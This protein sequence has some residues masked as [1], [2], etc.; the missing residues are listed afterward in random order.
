MAQ[1]SE[2]LFPGGV[3][4]DGRAASPFPLSYTRA[5]KAEKVDLD[6]NVVIDYW[7]GNGALMLGHNPPAVT[8]AIAAQI[9]NGTHFGGGHPYEIQ[10]AK[11]IVELVPSAEQVRFVASGTAATLLALR[12]ARAKTGRTRIARFEGHF[13]GWNDWM[14]VGNRY[15]FDRPS[16]GGIPPSVQSEIIVLPNDDFSAAE[17]ALADRDVAGIILEPG[18]GTQGRVPLANTMLSG[19]RE[20]CDA[21]D[22]TLIF[23]EVVSGFRVD[24]GGVQRQ[25]GITPDITTLAKIAAGGLPGGAVCGATEYMEVLSFSQPAGRQ[26]IAHPGTFNANPLTAV[27]GTAMLRE[28]EDGEPLDRAAGSARILRDGLN[29]LIRVAGIAGCAYGD[30]S[31][32]HVLLGEAGERLKI[33]GGDPTELS[34]RGALAI[35]PDLLSGWRT[36]CMYHGLDLMGPTMMVSSVHTGEVVEESLSRFE[37]VFDTLGRCAELPIRV[38]RIAA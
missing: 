24:P 8:S 1:E 13:H 31:I 2:A 9:G 14:A 7:M 11:Q 26:R 38:E 37:R 23:D 25:T 32:V 34:P 10:W 30:R 28:I 17:A 21:T 20:L 15:P 16:S 4:H 5:D 12:I 19:L 6:G 27:A 33:S 29:E 22:T 3:T 18:G 35:N 36:A